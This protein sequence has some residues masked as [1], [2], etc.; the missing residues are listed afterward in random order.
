MT[1]GGFINV[2]IE[3][4]TLKPSISS[5]DAKAV[6]GY[7]EA[8]R[9]K[10]KGLPFGG[11]LVLYP[12]REWTLDLPKVLSLASIGLLIIGCF[13]PWYRITFI[14]SQ[15]MFGFQSFSGVIILLMSLLALATH[16]FNPPILMN[17][18]RGGAGAVNFLF[19]VFFL[20]ASKSGLGSEMPEFARAVLSISIGY[21]FSFLGVTGMLASFAI[22]ALP[23]FQSRK[24]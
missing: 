8:A 24:S 11:P 18:V 10:V 7:L 15:S 4:T 17:F 23:F 2:P 21:Y 12:P 9:E 1:L 14:V 16:C 19:L 20:L 3:K 13:L 6:S 22:E 5:I